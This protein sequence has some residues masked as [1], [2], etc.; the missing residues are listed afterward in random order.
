M[1][2]LAS[3]TVPAVQLSGVT[4]RYGATT[5]VDQI[6]LTLAEGEFLTLLGPSG[7]GKS[8]VLSLIAGFAEPTEGDIFLGGTRVNDLPAYRRDIAMMFQ[9]YALFPNMTVFDNVRFPLRVRGI[10]GPSARERVMAA[11]AMVNLIGFEQRWPHELS[12]GQQQRVSLARALVHRPKVLLLDEPLA[13]LDKRLRDQMQLEIRRIH[14]ESGITTICVTH[15]QQEAM[16][17]SDRI[18]VME[19]GQIRQIGDGADVYDRPVSRFVAGFVGD[20]NFFTAAVEG[21]D[22]VGTVARVGDRMAVRFRP[23]AASST[24]AGEKVE[25]GLR[26]GRILLSSEA[27]GPIGSTNQ[28]EAIVEDSVFLG[29]FVVYRLDLGGGWTITAN[30]HRRARTSAFPVGDRIWAAWTEDD[31]VPL[32]HA[33]E[34]GHE[35]A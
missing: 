18:A 16:V 5:A 27:P 11:L 24:S 4:K 19:G 26:P 10:R 23:G 21:R 31:L 28:V 32:G 1:E 20:T 3:S 8:T 13:A 17:M 7:S 15:D 35:V 33:K 34:I 2:A 12:G 30:V 25:L 9:S 22:S 29:D 14:R 6:D